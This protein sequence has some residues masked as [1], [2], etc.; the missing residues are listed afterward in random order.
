MVECSFAVGGEDRVGFGGARA[1]WLH[2]EAEAAHEFNT[3][4][5]RPPSRRAIAAAVSQG[6]GQPVELEEWR[7]REASLCR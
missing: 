2:P 7:G 1:G 6:W 4:A 3:A 5:H